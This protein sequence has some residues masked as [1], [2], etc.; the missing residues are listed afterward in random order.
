M[1]DSI[2]VSFDE[3]GS[4]KNASGKPLRPSRVAEGLGARVSAVGRYPSGSDR[5][6]LP[7][8]ITEFRNTLHGRRA[9]VANHERHTRQLRSDSTDYVKFPGDGNRFREHGPRAFFVGHSARYLFQT[10]CRNWPHLKTAGEFGAQ[11]APHTKAQRYTKP[12]SFAP[13]PVFAAL[14]RCWGRGVAQRLC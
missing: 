3:H 2:F 11:R 5:P 12:K 4:S 8:G 13:I 9:A 6:T 1:A 7:P 14:D 10:D